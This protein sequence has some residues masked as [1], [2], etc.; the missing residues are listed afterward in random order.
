VR[1][2]VAAAQLTQSRK[3]HLLRPLAAQ[4]MSPPLAA[5]DTAERL[6]IDLASLR[7]AE[8]YRQM[9]ATVLAALTRGEIAPAE[10]A[11]IAQQ[12]C[13]CL[14]AVTRLARFLVF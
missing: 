3:P 7:T 14:R 12:M 11:R 1:A 9:L 5:C 6:W 4:L 8:D 10:G 13:A 2:Y